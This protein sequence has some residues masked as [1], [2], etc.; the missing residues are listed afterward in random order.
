MHFHRCVMDGVFAVGE[1]GQVRF[2][3]AG[4]LTPED[5]AAFQRQVRAR[6]LRRFA[7][8]AGVDAL[9]IALRMA[10]FGPRV[11]TTECRKVAD[12]GQ[13]RAGPQISIDQRSKQTEQSSLSNTGMPRRVDTLSEV[14]EG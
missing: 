4:V 10:A 3:E 1:D 13:P 2:A 8:C 14:D 7:P 12:T 6:A 9:V 5:L 11:P